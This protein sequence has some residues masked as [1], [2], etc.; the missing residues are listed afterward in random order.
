MIAVA[1][2]GDLVP[3]GI[4]PAYRGILQ[5]VQALGIIVEFLEDVASCL[6]VAV[7]ER[8]AVG[9]AADL[10]ADRID[11]AAGR[12]HI[13]NTVN[14]D[15]FA[16]YLMVGEQ[17]CHNALCQQDLADSDAVLFQGVC[18]LVRT[19]VD[20]DGIFYL[21]QDAGDQLGSQF[22]QIVLT[23][24]QR[25]VVHPQQR[26]GQFLI[27]CHI[28][29][30]DENASTGN[31]YFLVQ[32]N[33]DRLSL[34]CLIH[35]LVRHEDAL[36]SSS[37][38]AGQRGDGIAHVNRASLDLTLE[39][40]ESMVRT[41]HTLYRHIKALFVAVRMDVHIFQ[42]FQE[43]NAVIPRNILRL[44]GHVVA[45]CCRQR[46]DVYIFQIQFLA[47]F[48]DLCLDLTETLFT[49]AHQVHLVYRKDEIADTHELADPC[50]A[51]GLYQNALGCVHQDDGQVSEGCA[52]C[53]VTGILFV[54]RCIC[55][56]KAAVVGGEIAVCHVNGD[57]LFPLCHQTIQKQRIVDR[58]AAAAHL[59]VQFQ[60]LF[61]VCVQQLC[62]I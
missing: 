47:E 11:N 5:H 16:Q 14:E 50:M 36:D 8:I 51:S 20:I 19:G 28:C 33:G 40:T 53:H 30:L 10:F 15:Q 61:L 60:G 13:G 39:S 55:N 35:G 1:A 27:H 23:D 56:D 24:A 32:R 12:C 62:I 22:Y 52:N 44:L 34:E 38:I 49:V 54:T 18:L 25:L 43:R 2:G 21:C 3:Y 58:T 37:F 6:E 4:S 41:A 45:L 59:A 7:L 46:N 9:S 31:V 48:C 57:T 42:V 17:V 26:N 29:I